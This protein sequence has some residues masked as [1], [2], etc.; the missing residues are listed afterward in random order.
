VHH[1]GGTTAALRELAEE[2]RAGVEARFGV[3][4]TEE[5]IY[6]GSP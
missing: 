6:L 3:K 4:L 1:G 5:P 2:I